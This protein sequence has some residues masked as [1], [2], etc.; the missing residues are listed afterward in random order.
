MFINVQ[1]FTLDIPFHFRLQ[2]GT[3]KPKLCV[4][5][6]EGTSQVHLR[7]LQT[8]T[9]VSFAFKFYLFV[10]SRRVRG[11]RVVPK[12]EESWTTLKIETCMRGI[13]E[14]FLPHR[15]NIKHQNWTLTSLILI[16]SKMWSA[17]SKIVRQSLFLIGGMCFIHDVC[18][19]TLPWHVLR[20]NVALGCK[21]EYCLQFY[22]NIV[23]IYII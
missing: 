21:F 6:G 16:Y 8:S 20:K 17:K 22:V 3:L 15:I 2:M 19:T 23:C 12:A 14:G 7:Y 13:S 5:I 9:R 10:P 11:R 18:S 1:S 4:F